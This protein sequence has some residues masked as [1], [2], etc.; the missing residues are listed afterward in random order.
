MINDQSNNL[1]NQTSTVN[2]F[3][4]QYIPNQDKVHLFINPV[5]NQNLPT[6]DQRPWENAYINPDQ[7]DYVPANE[8]RNIFASSRGLYH[9]IKV[10][11][12]R[13]VCDKHYLD[14]KMMTRYL[15]GDAPLLSL[16]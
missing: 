14:I 15:S 3:T 10:R 4:E 2:N 12:Q 6:I 16:E 11:G 8:L 5:N 13:H 7:F 1:N 9:F